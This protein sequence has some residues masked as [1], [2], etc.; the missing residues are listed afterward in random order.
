M[1]PSILRR[2]LGVTLSL[3]SVLSI[4]L[5]SACSS[6]I[7]RRQPT[8][9]ERFPD[10]Q[11]QALDGTV[12]NLPGDL[13]GAPAI[14]LIGYV[15]DA[16]FDLDR[17]L[18]GLAQLGTPVKVLEVPTIPGLVP[19]LFAGT[20]DSGMRSGIPQE[21][22]GG[23]VTVYDDGQAIVDFLGNERPRNGRVVLLDTAG[24]VVWSADRGYSAALVRDLDATARRLLAG[25]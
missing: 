4:V 22:W 3:G 1:R 21:D 8:P 11:G 25:R 19:G 12:W 13:A 17:W 20:I 18:L 23:V 24:G 15:Q 5:A 9:G 2:G 16:Q 10:V 6:T 14:L 7:P